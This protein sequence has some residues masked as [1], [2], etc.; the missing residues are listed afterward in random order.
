M[1]KGEAAGGRGGVLVFFLVAFGWSWT[2]GL[3][4]HVL[5]WMSPAKPSPYAA[6]ALF[7]Y[8]CGPAI[9]AVVAAMAFDRGR[10]RAALGLRKPFNLWLVPAWLAPLAL[11][12]AALGFTLAFSGYAYQPLEVA[13]EQALKAQGRDQ[14]SLPMSIHAIALLQLASAPLI[15]PLINWPLLLTEELGWRGWLWDRWA[16]LGFWPNVLATGLVWGLWHAPIVM[17]G[18]NYPGMPVLGPILMIALCVGLSAPLHHIRERGGSV[19]HAA[20]FHG[21]FNAVG[22]L[23]IA[24]VAGADMPWRGIVGAGGFMALALAAAIVFLLRLRLAPAR[25]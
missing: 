24:L 20:L 25:G 19:W 9:G 2:I 22:A 16:R 5:G 12:A 14:A 3:I 23:S 8:M 11:T 21:T 4:I 6:L 15:G 7:V 1:S 13:I 10:R 18:F 17:L